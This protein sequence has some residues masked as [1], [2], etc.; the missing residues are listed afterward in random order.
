MFKNSNVYLVECL[1][2]WV[3]FADSILLVE[4]GKSDDNCVELVKEYI[5][6]NRLES[7]VKLYHIEFT[8]FADSRNKC[9]EFSDK[10]CQFQLILDDSYVIVNN[11]RKELVNI[12]KKYKSV[13]FYISS[14]Y[15][16][17]IMKRCIRTN[18]GL[19]YNGKIHE[20]IFDNN[21]YF[22]DKVLVK[23]LTSDYMKN[24]TDQRLLYDLQCLNIVDTPKELYMKC[25]LY[26]KAYCKKIKT[27]E[28]T[29]NIFLKRT[30]CDTIDIEENFMTRLFLGHIY[31]VCYD[32]GDYTREDIN[33]AFKYYLEASL[34]FPSRSG[35]CYFY[36]YLISDLDIYLKKAYE[37]RFI[38]N[39]RL[40]V[41][42]SL[43]GDNGLIFQKHSQV[44]L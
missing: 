18:S 14:E 23:D 28:E 3:Q 31:M 27:K 33:Q 34:I 16:T 20:T 9:F 15:S 29:I 5:N 38:G 35:E 24:R 37:K 30:L 42:L 43:Y 40:P 32:S 19:R 22:I 2:N 7:I 10:K 44:F 25:L 21:S 4:G 26:Y 6:T 36:A 17:Y 12:P 41:D 1:K 11:I 13:K 39:Y 8:N